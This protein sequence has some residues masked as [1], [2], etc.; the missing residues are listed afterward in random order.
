[1]GSSEAK[2]PFLFR[3]GHPLSPRSELARARAPYVKRMAQLHVSD[4]FL[5][6]A[7]WHVMLGGIAKVCR[8]EGLPKKRQEQYR[9]KAGL[10]MLRTWRRLVLAGK[11]ASLE[12]RGLC[13]RT[14]ELTLDQ[15]MLLAVREAVTDVDMISIM[16]GL[17]PIFDLG[18]KAA[19]RFDRAIETGKVREH[20]RWV[21][22]TKG[23]SELYRRR[24]L[25]ECRARLAG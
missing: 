23:I 24:A 12:D 1:M 13:P 14:T 22:Q 16:H 15:R 8:D 21:Q 20:A 11:V 7:I 4:W 17:A 5:N 6:R 10:R 2:D 3:D 18:Y 19:D 9:A 25:E